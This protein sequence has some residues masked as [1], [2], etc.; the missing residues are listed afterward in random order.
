MVEVDI[1]GKK[2]PLCLTVTALD[3]VNEKCGGLKNLMPFLKG[4]GDGAKAVYNTAWMLG[5]MIFEGEENRLV[6]ARFDGEK[7]ERR[8]VPDST[9]ICHLLTPATARAYRE[10]VLE[11]V[12]ESMHQEIEAERQKNAENAGR[13]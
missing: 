12:T 1:R 6:C 13:A 4:Y 8:A 5:L 10:A 2:F 7:V 3:K 9:A 11:A